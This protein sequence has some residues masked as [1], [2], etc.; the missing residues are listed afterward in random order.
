MLKEMGL[1]GNIAPLILD[2][3]CGK[4]KHDE[5]QRA[6]RAVLQESELQQ[7]HLLPECLCC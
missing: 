6:D 4:A 1:D 3:K 2:Y 7:F 5:A